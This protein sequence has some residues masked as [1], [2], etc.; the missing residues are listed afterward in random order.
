MSELLG[1]GG[2]LLDRGDDLEREIVQH[3]GMRLRL[4]QHHLVQLAHFL[5]VGGDDL[6]AA[7]QLALQ[8]QDAVFEGLE[9]DPRQ[10]LEDV[11]EAEDRGD[12]V[13]DLADHPEGDVREAGVCD[14][15]VGHVS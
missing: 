1:V 4:L 11:E 8:R 2:L 6:V 15:G 14:G 10:P 13:A 3:L 12:G 5:F 9:V 7:L